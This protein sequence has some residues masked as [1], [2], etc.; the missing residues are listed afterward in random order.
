[1]AKEGDK[2][3]KKIK[4]EHTNLRF[5][6]L[7]V[8]IYI[9]GIIL[10]A[11]LFQ[12]QIV[13][14]AEYREASNTRLSRESIFDATRGD[15]VDRSGTMLATTT[16]SFNLELYKTKNDDDSLNDCIK[17]LI[18]LFEKYNISYANNF[19]VNLECTAFTIEEENLNKWFT[20]NKIDSNTTPEQV[21]EIFKKKYKIKN[22]N[23]QEAR[24]IISLR[25]EITTKGYSNTRPLNLAENVPN[26][27][28]AQVSERNFDFPG[29]SIVTQ[30]TRKYDNQNLA[31]HI[32]GYIGK[33]SESEYD[34]KKDVYNNDDY[35]G[36][37]GI[38][39]SFE[40]YLRG[41][42]RKTGSRNVC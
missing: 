25:Y 37:T 42:R 32:L 39:K 20:K 27:V 35:V 36:R 40:E 30:S 2:L 16:N 7:I 23:L 24:K 38:E 22:D 9:I 28:I 41:K 18:E 11:Q 31:S 15:V 34:E 5:N 1:M 6:I 3:R 13:N 14:G 4:K 26:E 17:N 8:I 19:P 29:V 12:L 21:V 10:I 33:I